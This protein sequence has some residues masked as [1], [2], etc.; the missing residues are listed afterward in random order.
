MRKARGEGE[1]I[2]INVM[3]E[4]PHWKRGARRP[5]TWFQEVHFRMR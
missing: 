5:K 4:D 2:G 3:L 1:T